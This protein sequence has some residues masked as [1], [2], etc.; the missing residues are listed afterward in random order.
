MGFYLPTRK[1][2]DFVLCFHVI[3]P[4]EKNP[5]DS[6]MVLSQGTKDFSDMKGALLAD[7]DRDERE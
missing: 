5:L 1:T 2:V 7:A 3:L 4:K 6:S